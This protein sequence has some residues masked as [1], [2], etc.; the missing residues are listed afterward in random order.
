MNEGSFIQHLDPRVKL[1]SFS[2]LAVQIVSLHTPAMQ[3]GLT[4]ILLAALINARVPFAQIA[5]SIRRIS[6]FLVAIML[7]ATFTTSGDILLSAGVLYAT[8][9]GL[10][11]G[12]RLSFQLLL[13]ALFAAVFV[14]TTSIPSLIDAVEAC[15]RPFR[16][17]IGGIVQVL[18]I[19]VNFIP[20][21]IHNA[22]QIKNAQIVQGVDV[23]GNFLR[24]IR[25]ALSAAAP[26]FA[27]AFRT[28][29]QLAI[30]MD[31]RCYSPTGY[32][33]RFSDL[34]M[35]PTDWVFAAGAL[36]QFTL[37]YLLAL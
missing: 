10:A 22:R 24:Q 17:K 14:K 7:F 16:Q 27:R 36:V 31:S 11:T 1:L 9:E 13:L 23:D 18:T 3:T 35:Q 21:L 20:L 6:V 8:R 2:L 29:D 34:S 33:S 28:S 5:S 37:S 32:R 30:A 4:I 15:A 25:F 19:A 12:L 26:L